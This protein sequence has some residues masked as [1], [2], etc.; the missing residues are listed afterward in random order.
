[1]I[2]ST[3]VASTATSMVD[4]HSEASGVNCVATDIGNISCSAV[5]VIS[6]FA[7]TAV[8]LESKAL[9]A[10]EIQGVRNAQQRMG[11]YQ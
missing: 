8:T 1:M 3:L 2:A 4:V 7:R 10:W 9:E 5:T 6:V 11:F